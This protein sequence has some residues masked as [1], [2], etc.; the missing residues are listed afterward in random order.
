MEG[1]FDKPILVLSLSYFLPLGVYERGCPQKSLP[2][3]L[4]VGHSIPVNSFPV[5]NRM[6][7]TNVKKKFQ[8]AF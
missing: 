5:W 2:G 3:R 7:R 1:V 6:D 4:G 8:S